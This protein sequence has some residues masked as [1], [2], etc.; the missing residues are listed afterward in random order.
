MMVSGGAARGTATV[1]G[2]VLTSS[3]GP[4]RRL[5]DGWVCISA[6]GPLGDTRIAIIVAVRSL[7]SETEKSF[8][9]ASKPPPS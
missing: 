6:F 5:G 9:L 4:A 1:D 8:P 2:T 7:S 3:F